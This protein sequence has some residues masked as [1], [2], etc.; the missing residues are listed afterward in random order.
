MDTMLQFL[1]KHSM[2]AA[3]KLTAE[4][5]D[6][7]QED[8]FRY[9]CSDWPAH[10]WGVGQNGSIAGIVIHLASWKQRLIPL[11]LGET[12]VQHEEAI[13]ALAPDH[14]DNWQSIQNWFGKISS[15]WNQALINL[16]E[17]E[18]D[19]IKYWEGGEIQLSKIVIN[20]IDHDI[21]HSS[22]IEYLKQRILWESKS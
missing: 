1:H 9:A 12:A 20:I 6:V 3:D 22:Q 18:M 7:S 11:M 17:S 8:A 16:S 2:K 4:L 10:K 21:Q 5:S 19:S 14:N 15:E 13:E